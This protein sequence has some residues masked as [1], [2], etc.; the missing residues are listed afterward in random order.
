MF[1]LSDTEARGRTYAAARMLAGLN[2]AE[3]GE[4][5]KLSAATVSNVE[6]GEDARRTTTRSIKKALNKHGVVVSFS[7]RNG[8][9]A[10]TIRFDSTDDEDD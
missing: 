1:S 6:R 10:V 4:L 9:A 8:I 7:P 3:L 5:A 2:Q